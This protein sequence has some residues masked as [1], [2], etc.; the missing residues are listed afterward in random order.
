MYGYA[1]LGALASSS[2][3]LLLPLLSNLVLLP[4]FRSFALVSSADLHTTQLTC[5]SFFSSALFPLLPD[6][7]LPPDISLFSPSFRW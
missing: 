6:L 4:V 1:C 3:V 5:F 7:V 2:G